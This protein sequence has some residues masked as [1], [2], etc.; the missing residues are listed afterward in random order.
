LNVILERFYELSGDVGVDGVADAFK[1][2]WSAFNL[3]P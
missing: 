1:D 2:R 3:F